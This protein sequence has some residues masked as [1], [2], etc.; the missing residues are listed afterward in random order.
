MGARWQCLRPRS[1]HRSEQPVGERIWWTASARF[2]GLPIAS[3]HCRPHPTAA[4]SRIPSASAI[5]DFDGRCRLASRPDCSMRGHRWQRRCGL[6]AV[7]SVVR[8]TKLPKVTDPVV[9]AP[10][11]L[12]HLRRTSKETCSARYSARLRIPTKIRVSH[13][14]T[15]SGECPGV[16]VAAN[17]WTVAR[18][19]VAYACPGYL[20]M[21]DGGQ[22]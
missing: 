14:A 6:I 17:I 2:T 5:S 18:R 22:L 10:A 20:P 15:P 4:S 21:R 8:V 12:R 7:A 13:K 19:C 16:A 1:G 9:F 11:L 3:T